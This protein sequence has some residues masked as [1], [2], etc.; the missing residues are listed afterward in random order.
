MNRVNLVKKIKEKEIA[1]KLRKQGKTYSEILSIVPVA[2]STLALWLH[3]VKLA[4]KQ[5]QRVTKER[6]AGSRR[7]GEVKKKQRIEK[8]ESIILK[9]KSEI[10][11]LSKR[12]LF[13]I[14]VVLYWA[15]GSKEKENNPGSPLRFANSD[16]Y[17]IKLFLNW[18]K[19]IGVDEKRICF[20]IYLHENNKYRVFEV[21]KYWVKQT[22]FSEKFFRVYFKKNILKTKR[23]NVFPDSYF[24]VTRIYVKESSD[25]VR[26]INGW[27]G[28]IVEHL[29]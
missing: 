22:N 27:V 29:K 24:G 7:G 18:L 17:M 21:V 9:S 13:L 10:N 5:K 8:Q 20:D 2:K 6:L 19:Y 11:K 28:G 3:S 1:I 14:G 4:K 26:K 15:E 23:K 12:E 16:P 25:L